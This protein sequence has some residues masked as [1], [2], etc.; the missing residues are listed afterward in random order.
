MRHFD[1]PS[2]KLP[3]FLCGVF[4][5][6]I[7][8]ACKK[9]LNNLKP[10]GNNALLVDTSGYVVGAHG[11]LIPQ[12]NFHII[13]K[14]YKLAIQNQHVYKVEIASGKLVEDFGVYGPVTTRLQNNMSSTS[15][16]TPS[17]TVDATNLSR[18]ESS[19]GSNSLF[20]T[21]SG[22]VAAEEWQNPYPFPI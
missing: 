2:R 10:A 21:S 18:A 1:F 9:D 3:L 22:W 7:F 17:G 13:E 6:V 8:S 20:G 15:M 12:K 5:I 4:S 11:E 16:M 19:K 14:G